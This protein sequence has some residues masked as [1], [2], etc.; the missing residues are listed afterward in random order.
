MQAI[1]REAEEFGLGQRKY[2]MI[3]ALSAI[4]L[5]SM[6]I[7]CLGMIFC[8]SALLLVWDSKCPSYSNTTNMCCH[9][10]A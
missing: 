6:M 9:F 1:T 2:Y 10:L 8:S 3:L 7:G 4:S 5:Q